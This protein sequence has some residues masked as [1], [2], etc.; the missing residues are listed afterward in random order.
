MF[1]ETRSLIPSN[2]AATPGTDRDKTV[3]IV[4]KIGPLSEDLVDLR[5]RL[6]S[7]RHSSLNEFA[8]QLSGS[9]SSIGVKISRFLSWARLI[10][11]L[12]ACGIQYPCF[13]ELTGRQPSYSISM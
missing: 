9:F 4:E 3:T 8:L 6:S 11:S 13:L 2:P 7:W 5:M 12:V 1:T 10:A